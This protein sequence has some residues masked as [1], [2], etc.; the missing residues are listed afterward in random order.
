MQD[1]DLRQAIE[2]CLKYDYQLADGTIV[3]GQAESLLAKSLRHYGLTNVPSG[4]ELGVAARAYGFEL[5]YAKAGRQ[6]KTGYS[7]YLPCRAWVKPTP[8]NIEGVR[9]F[10][11]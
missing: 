11:A 9:K 4:R 1:D 6:T 5:V 7:Y 8:D 10:K 3:K 2:N